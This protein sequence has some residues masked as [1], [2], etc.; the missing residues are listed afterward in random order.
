MTSN[1]DIP[2]G[3]GVGDLQTMAAN[4]H[5]RA[6]GFLANVNN[7]VTDLFSFPMGNIL[8]AGQEAAQLGY[9][10]FNSGLQMAGLVSPPQFRNQYPLADVAT[11]AFFPRERGAIGSALARGIGFGYNYDMPISLGE[12]KE[13]YDKM[14]G[15]KSL[16]NIVGLASAGLYFVNPLAGIGL[17]VA[18]QGTKFLGYE[19]KATENLGAFI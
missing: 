11:Q 2:G 1:A 19:A 7:F 4:A 18:Y 6:S 5:E 15:K 9:H 16:D 3:T 12:Y 8:A 17:E 14:I 10:K 13:T